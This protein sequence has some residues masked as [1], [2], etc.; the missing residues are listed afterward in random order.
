[1]KFEFDEIGFKDDI[2]LM[3]LERQMEQRQIN[4]NQTLGFNI[5]QLYNAID[6]IND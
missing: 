4:N 5:D 2:E 1:M 6:N 3:N